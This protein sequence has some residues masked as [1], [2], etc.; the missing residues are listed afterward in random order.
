MTQNTTAAEPLLIKKYSNRRLYNTATSSYITL[1]DLRQIVKDG[2]D[3]VVRDAKTNEDLTRITLAQI[4]LEQ[5][6]K[7]YDLLPIS[8]LRQI[9]CVYDDA[10]SNVFSQYLTTSTEAFTKNQQQMQEYLKSPMQGFMGGIED[11]TKKN[12]KIFEDTLKALTEFA[13]DKKKD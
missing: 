2:V 5:E 13:P 12:L 6:S 8:F 3:F 9:I 7:G 10:L 11:I 4:I 1:E